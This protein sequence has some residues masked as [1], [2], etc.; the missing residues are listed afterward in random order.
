MSRTPANYS[1]T[2]V[3]GATV[4][5]EFTYTDAAGAAIDLTG[6]EARM[7]VRTVAGQ[8]GL[9]T[10]TTLMLE[11]TTANELLEW[12]TAETGRLRIVVPPEDHA[13]LNPTNLKRVKYVYALEVYIP[14]GVEPEYVI[15]LVQGNITVLGEITR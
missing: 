9:T 6:Y 10:A 13:D 1:M 15:P 4:E 7:Q 3:R 5:D 14:A 2:W 11:L 8:Y 12:D